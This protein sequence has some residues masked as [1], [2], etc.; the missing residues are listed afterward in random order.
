MSALWPSDTELSK[1]K[2]QLEHIYSEQNQTVVS[3]P[4]QPTKPNIAHH[5]NILLHRV[6]GKWEWECLIW[7]TE[8][9]TFAD[10]CIKGTT[11]FNRKIAA[12]KNMDSVLE[13]FGI[14]KKTKNKQLTNK[15]KSV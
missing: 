14:T 1:I 9:S 12:V 11:N 8:N 2:R 13:K 7:F 3:D 15:N 10:V 4:I 6:N 5:R